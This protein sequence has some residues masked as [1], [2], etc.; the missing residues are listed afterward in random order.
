MRFFLKYP[1]AM[2]YLLVELRRSILTHGVSKINKNRNFG[3]RFMIHLQMSVNCRGKLIDLSSPKVMGI[4]NL[5]PDSFYDGGPF[6][7][8]KSILNHVKKMMDEGAVIIDIGAMSSRPGAVI[9][10]A[11]E[12]LK[13]L[14]PALK[15]IIRHFPEAIISVDT[16]HAKVAAEALGLGVH[17]INDISGG[18]FDAEM[19]PLMAKA[20]ATYIVMHMHGSP[21]TMQENPV[22]KN[23]LSDVF[24]FLLERIKTCRIAGITDIIIDPGLVLERTL[25]TIMLYCTT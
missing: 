24:D 14:L 6:T 20:K 17:I 5:T 19:I 4:L 18:R 9:I 15:S 7:N 13:R 16:I 10:T 25:S 23:V 12:E 11:G 2:F 8:E 1:A 3:S 22:Y 21:D